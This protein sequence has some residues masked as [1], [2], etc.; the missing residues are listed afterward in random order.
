[1]SS[2]K[3]HVS[4]YE[5]FQRMVGWVTSGMDKEPQTTGGMLSQSFGAVGKT[6][7]FIGWIY[8]KTLGFMFRLIKGGMRMVLRRKKKEKPADDP[9]FIPP[10]LAQQMARQG[11]PVGGGIPLEFPSQGVPVQP[12]QPVE[13]VQRPPAQPPVQQPY[14]L[15][16]PPMPPASVPT[17]PAPPVFQPPA[18]Q[19]THLPPQVV[20]RK[21][22]AHTGDVLEQLMQT[23]I[24]LGEKIKEQD[25]RLAVVENQVDELYRRVNKVLGIQS[26][27]DSPIRFER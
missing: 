15:P 20:Q 2:K 13:H 8:A 1:M 19:I 14:Q 21:A 7:V 25:E 27:G 11:I 6:L 18:Q 26:A 23:F 17:Q 16:T 4:T 10:Q 24:S 9:A 22:S 3:K 12:V 5:E